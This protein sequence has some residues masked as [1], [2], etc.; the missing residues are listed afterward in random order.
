MQ[1]GRDRHLHLLPND[2]LDFQP[3]KVIGY[4]VDV[5]LNPD[6]QREDSVLLLNI[7]IH[8]PISINFTTYQRLI[9]DVISTL[10]ETEIDQSR[11]KGVLK[12][13]VK[14]IWKSSTAVKHESG[15]F[16]FPFLTT[17]VYTPMRFITLD[18]FSNDLLFK[19]TSKIALR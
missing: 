5:L 1:R 2:D 3:N 18:L 4:I 17:Q 15:S 8:Y 12:H 10:G 14:V 13:R 9:N 6:M 7:G 16:P 11:G 19:Y